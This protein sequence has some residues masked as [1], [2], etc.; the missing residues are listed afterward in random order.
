MNDREQYPCPECN[1]TGTRRE[2]WGSYRDGNRTRVKVTCY[3]CEGAGV[4]TDADM[5]N[6]NYIT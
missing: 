4:V 6:H 3:L 1:G 5:A 2:W